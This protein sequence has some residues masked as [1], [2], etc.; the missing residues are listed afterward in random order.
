MNDYEIVFNSERIN[1]CRINEMFIDNYVT[2]INNPNVS[3]YISSNAMH[4]TYE[5][6]RDWIRSRIEE[7]AHVFTMVD[8]ETNRFIGNIEIMNIHNG[9]AEIGICITEDMQNNHYGREAMV[10]ITNYGYEVMN[11][12]TIYLNVFDFNTR[13]IRCYQNAGY[14]IAGPGPEEHDIRM[15]HRR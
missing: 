5:E 11:L 8:R 14:I 4:V 12:E 13:A 2:M 7:N 3:R 9:M 1:F 10:A 15:V 6:E